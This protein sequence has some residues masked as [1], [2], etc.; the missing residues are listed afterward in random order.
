MRLTEPQKVALRLLK[1]VG[2]RTAYPGMSIGTLNSLALKGLV[3]AD[4]SRPGSM[5]MPRTSI[6]WSITDD[7]RAAIFTLISEEKL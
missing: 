1:K 6:I 4:R 7:G 5:A 2:P 3:K